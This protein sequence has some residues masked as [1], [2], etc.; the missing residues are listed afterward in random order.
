VW[1]V[2]TFKARW[3]EFDA[4]DDAT[5]GSALAEAARRCDPRLFGVRTDDAVGLMAAHL[6]SISPFGTQARLDSDEADT[7]YRRE[8]LTLARAAAGGP[9]TIG[10][11]LS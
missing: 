9:W 6:L 10:E 5:L 8:W 7:T 4:T 2:A 3:R 11:V 1:D